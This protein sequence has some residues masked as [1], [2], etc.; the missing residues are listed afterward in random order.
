[1]AYICPAEI[2]WEHQLVNFMHRI[3]SGVQKPNPLCL[4][5]SLPKFI[6]NFISLVKLSFLTFNFMDENEKATQ[7]NFLRCSHRVTDCTPEFKASFLGGGGSKK[8]ERQKLQA[9]C[10]FACIT[11]V[12]G[13]QTL[14]K[15]KLISQIPLKINEPA[16][17]I[18]HGDNEWAELY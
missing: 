17:R 4:N 14:R 1:M 3:D 12:F 11:H 15:R 13:I 18:G 2:T 9:I 16:T 7:I 10:W 8:G 6:C 5:S